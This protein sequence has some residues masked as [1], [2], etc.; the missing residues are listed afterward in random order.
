[1]ETNMKKVKIMVEE[2][3]FLSG[4]LKSV[5]KDQERTTFYLFKSYLEKMQDEGKLKKF[6]LNTVAF[7]IFGMINW[8]DHWY[9]RNKRLSL[10]QIADQIVEILF[11][12]LLTEDARKEI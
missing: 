6:D 8:L 4:R 10:M 3:R 2:K 9:Q 7:G 12:G 1:M 11:K 5:I